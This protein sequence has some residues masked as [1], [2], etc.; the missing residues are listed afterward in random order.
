M[1]N[2][3]L[4]DNLVVGSNKTEESIMG[5]MNEIELT[6]S[7]NSLS[8]GL[9]TIMN[10]SIDNTIRQKINIIR[11]IL[12]DRE[13]FFLDNPT[14]E[15]DMDT[16]KKVASMIKKYLKDKTYIIVSNRPVITTICKKHY[17]IKDNTLK[18]KEPLL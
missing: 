14:Y 15:V 16:E 9:D 3:D 2:M 11:G 12:M 17:F 1:L 6:S 4:R 5:L 13:V 10:D 18:N 8:D 7:Y